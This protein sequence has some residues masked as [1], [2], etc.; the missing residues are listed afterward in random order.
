MH[1]GG[2][3]DPET[4]RNSLLGT[5]FAIGR[6]NSGART[7]SAQRGP[8]NVN[9]RNKKLMK[10]LLNS[11]VL[12]A[13]VALVA[14]LPLQARAQ[15]GPGG[16]GGGGGGGGRGN[17]S[18]E[19]MRQRM[20]DRYREMLDIKN[21]DEWKAI[22][23]RITK[24]M[25]ARQAVGFGGGMR[26]MFGNRRG[27]GGDTQNADQGQRRRGGFGGQPSPAAEDLQKAID[28]K[29]SSDTIKA[30]LTAYRD[31]RT[32]KRSDLQKAQDDLKKVLNVRQEAAAVLA[33]LLD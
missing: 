4:V 23:P 26:G 21:D 19:E 29:A 13:V 16:G 10:R 33:G 15:Q 24:V 8:G 27:G 25:D 30:K 18:P 2:G 7:A 3:A 32:Q 17:F 22:E 12:A 20:M 31:E 11:A 28:A 14:W 1:T 9:K 6:C 5:A